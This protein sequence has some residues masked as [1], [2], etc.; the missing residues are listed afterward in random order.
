MADLPARGAGRQP[1]G[2]P[3]CLTPEQPGV[4]RERAPRMGRIPGAGQRYRGA[5]IA[6]GGTPY[7]DCRYPD[8]PGKTEPCR[9]SQASVSSIVVNHCARVGGAPPLRAARSGAAPR[10]TLS[11]AAHGVCAPHGRDVFVALGDDREKGGAPARGSTGSGSP[12]AATPATENRDS[13]P[14]AR[15]DDHRPVDG[16]G[17][18]RN[19]AT[20]IRAG[21]T[22]P[23][24]TRASITAGTSAATSGTQRS[25]A[26]RGPVWRVVR[27]RSSDFP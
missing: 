24:P 9:V 8:R 3:A 25:S 22:A 12:G 10:G 19:T 13:H 14:D 7:T 11:R 1:S 18:H 21:S 2:E 5:V 23:S 27:R 6:E 16:V 17:A 15:L 4:R 20:P 26:S